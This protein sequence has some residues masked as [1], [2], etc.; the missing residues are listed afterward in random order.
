MRRK[1]TDFNLVR[2]I[3]SMFDKGF[4]IRPAGTID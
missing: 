4:L 3:L 1:D 2:S